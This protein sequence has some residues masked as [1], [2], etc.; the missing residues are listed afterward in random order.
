M[1]KRWIGALGVALGG[2]ACML[3]VMSASPRQASAGGFEVPENGTRAL[4][5]AGAYV[6][7][8]NEPSALYFNPAGLSRVRD[9]AVTANL[10]LIRGHI[11]FER[12]TFTF[13][14]SRTPGPGVTERTI[15]FEPVSNQ[16][17]YYPAPMLFAA[18]NFGLERW[19][20]AIGVYGPSA[21]GR[22]QYPSMTVRPDP[23]QEPTGFHPT[24]AEPV[25]TRDGGQSYMVTDY[26]LL[27]MYPS[28]AVA[29]EFPDVGLSIGLTVQLALLKVE[30]GVAV[31]GLFGPGSTGRY[32]DEE[33]IFYS[34]TTLDVNGMTA[35]G[36]VGVMW[37]ISD[38]FSVGA[39]YRPR[40]RIVADGSIDV[41]F[42][43][44]LEENEPRLDT[45]GAQ[46]TTFL[47]DV[48][49]LGGIYRHLGSAGQEVFN[50]ELNLVYE[51]WSIVD[52]FDVELDGS[53]SDNSGT[54]SGQK[55]PNLFLRQ[56]YRDTISVRLGSDLAMLR[57]A[58]TGNGPVFRVG[59]Y[60]ETGASSEAY[61]KLDFPSFDRIGVAGGLSYHIGR[62]SIDAAAAFAFSPET[63]VENGR[64]DVLTPT[65]V[66]ND[67]QSANSERVV[68]DCAARTDT[69]GHPVNNGVYR[70]R[71]QTLS[72]GV[73][74][75]W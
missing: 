52:G 73:T 50:V 46:L 40:H 32:S 16:A 66:C 43:P 6:A 48:V 60:Y 17:G 75:G 29:H 28:I 18:S 58:S 7:G 56:D 11:E 64:F 37:D 4:G 44:A 45:N 1:T 70:T 49:R 68:E 25:V 2:T 35:T 67:P 41:Q 54:V 26:D 55:L 27:L 30:Y 71:F 15:Q 10:N 20:F 53:L 42:P 69:P 24:R 8:V 36:I 13:P 51:G 19:T 72:F 3:L 74:Y 5:R 59:G 23:N 21:L 34:P 9:H 12:E 31:D 14:S 22:G 33:D 38:R 39:S 47:P 61:T 57:S 63:V 65:W 62:F